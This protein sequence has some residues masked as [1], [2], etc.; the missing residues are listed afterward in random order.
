[1]IFHFPSF[2]LAPTRSI[3][4]PANYHMPGRR[5]IAFVQLSH[6]GSKT[7]VLRSFKRRLQLLLVVSTKSLASIAIN[8]DANVMRPARPWVLRVVHEA[9]LPF[10]GRNDA[11]SV[12]VRSTYTC[13]AFGTAATNSSCALGSS[14]ARY[15]CALS[16]WW[17]LPRTLK[18][19]FCNRLDVLV[20]GYQVH[21]PKLIA[22]AD[23][24]RDEI[25]RDRIVTKQQCHLS[26]RL[27]DDQGR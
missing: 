9:R 10:L 23:V 19:E 16:L 22:V 18:S 3:F 4:W 6:R 27:L 1:M 14:V 25:I 5:S 7:V 2:K 24:D 11:N 12:T 13:Q 17:C 21:F 20:D 15:M 8:G 26:L